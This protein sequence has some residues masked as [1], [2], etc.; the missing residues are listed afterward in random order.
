MT[1]T[2]NGQGQEREERS[3]FRRDRDR[4]LDGV[5]RRARRTN[6]Q[7]KDGENITECKGDHPQRKDGRRKGWYH[8]P[9]PPTLLAPVPCF[10]QPTGAKFDMSRSHPTEPVFAT[11]SHAGRMAFVLC[12]VVSR[13]RYMYRYAW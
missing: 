7:R 10:V 5:S 9:K 4:D 13:V 12:I 11:A 1:V 2:R 6:S 3:G 8:Q